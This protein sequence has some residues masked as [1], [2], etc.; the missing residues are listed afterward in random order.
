MFENIKR[1]LRLLFFKTPFISNT[2]V[3]EY[4][5]DILN[6]RTLIAS[7]ELPDPDGLKPGH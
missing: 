5:D 7:K 4:F 1:I 2:D 3:S 6:S